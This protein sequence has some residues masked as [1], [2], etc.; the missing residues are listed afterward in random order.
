MGH[1]A[2]AGV[3]G[4]SD[5]LD[6]A[7]LSA[8]VALSATWLERHA[9]RINALNVFPVP[10]GDTGLNMAL[11]L[12]CAADHVEA[13]GG[14]TLSDVASAIGT[15]AMMGAR[16]NSG[17]ILAQMLRAVARTLAGHDVV[18]AALLARALEAAAE[19]GYA[20]VPNPVEGT[21]LT[22]GRAA[23][24]AARE[25]AARH[26]DVVTVLDHA[27]RAACTSVE[28]TPDLLPILKEA[29]V[30]DA[31]GEGYR[32]VLEGMLKA[33]RGEHIDESPVRVDVWADL[34]AIHQGAD[35]HF[36]YCTEVLFQGRAMD[37]DAVRHRLENLGSSVLVVGDPEML[38]VHVHTLRP[39]AVLDLATYLGEIL[40]VKVDNMQR[41]YRAFARAAERKPAAAPRVLAGTGLVA[42]AQGGGFEGIFAG[43]GAVVVPGGRTM[44]PSVD[45]ILRAVYQVARE[46]VIILPNDRNVVPAAEQA[47]R[48]VEGR[49]A[50]VVPTHSM[51]QG[52][53][54]ALALNPE[55]TADENSPGILAAAGRC[56]TIDITRAVRDARIEGAVVERGALMALIDNRPVATARSI[57]ELVGAAL[58]RLGPGPWDIATIYIGQD[59]TT[60]GASAVANVI[61][62]RTG[63]QIE[64]VTGGQPHDEYIVSLE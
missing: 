1:S 15:G 41:E 37:A 12:R 8:A 61:G 50:I 11:T 55:A 5:V 20:G 56:H 54:A 28:H 3:S 4:T 18:D 2:P 32:V 19:A 60:D 44:N 64:I 14:G 62:A 33:V 53:A 51:P 13:A 29:S 47:V 57:E 24:E 48:L 46:E 30:V 45:E 16:G 49:P 6:G 31:G 10:D 52:V 38:R 7:G 42:V 21:I 35:D 40:K 43:L 58:G 36:G 26:A 59:G 34:S 39:G 25:A 17:V 9:E 23:A 63:A 27:H 22:V